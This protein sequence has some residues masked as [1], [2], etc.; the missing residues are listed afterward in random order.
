MNKMQKSLQT[1]L[2]FILIFL[3]I[4]QIGISSAFNQTSETDLQNDTTLPLEQTTGITP[5]NNT[6]IGKT[7]VKPNDPNKKLEALFTEVITPTLC[8]LGIIGNIINL[9][10]LTRKEMHSST[11]CFL[12]ALAVSDMMLLAMQILPAAISFTKWKGMS[13]NYIIASRYLIVVR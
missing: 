13:R 10:V 3:S 4:Y 5:A 2:F 11:N 6:P 9:I 1:H 12:I 7:P 8:V